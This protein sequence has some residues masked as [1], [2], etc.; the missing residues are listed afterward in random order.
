MPKRRNPQRLFPAEEYPSPSLTEEAITEI[1]EELK[2]AAKVSPRLLRP[3]L[4]QEIKN[5]K[6]KNFTIDLSTPRRAVN[7]ADPLLRPDPD[8][9]E[10]LRLPDLGIV[11]DTMSIIRVDAPFQYVMNEA[12]NDPTDAAAGMMEDQ[13][14]IAEIYIINNPAPGQIAII[15][16]NWNPYLIRIG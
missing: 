3:T 11:G 1:E 10:P 6:Y 12:T 9:L 7:P 13:F 8:Y 15:R 5:A 14:E 16:V 4:V 2:P